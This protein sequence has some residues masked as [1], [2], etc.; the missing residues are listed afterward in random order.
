M[1]MKNEIGG[2]DKD[3]KTFSSLSRPVDISRYNDLNFLF[4]LRPVLY[5]Y[6][7][8]SYVISTKPKSIEL[9]IPHR[10]GRRTSI[11]YK[12]VEPLTSKLVLTT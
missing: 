8:P 9:E 7:E 11:S 2:G 4:N 12:G 3:G 1:G 6:H 10:L 5:T